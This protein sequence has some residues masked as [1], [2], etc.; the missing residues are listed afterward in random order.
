MSQVQETVLTVTGMSC[1]SCV[2]HVDHAL[3]QLGGVAQVEVHLREGKV[4]VWHDALRAP[5]ASLVTALSDAGYDA[6][7]QG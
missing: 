3:K 7:A 6:A 1:A 4:H 5:V 2:R